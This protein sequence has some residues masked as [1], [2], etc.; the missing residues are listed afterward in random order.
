MYLATHGPNQL[1]TVFGG[2]FVQEHH[3]EA[4]HSYLPPADK[5]DF[6]ADFNAVLRALR[7]AL[8]LR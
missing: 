3:S 4:A 1:Q 6:V 8:S 5:H 2:E 7:S